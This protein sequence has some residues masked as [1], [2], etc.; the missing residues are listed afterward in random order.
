MNGP[1]LLPSGRRFGPY[2]ERR[3]ET[4]LVSKPFLG[5]VFSRRRISLLVTVCQAGTSLIG[6]AIVAA[7]ICSVPFRYMPHLIQAFDLG[8]NK[9]SAF[10]TLHHAEAQPQVYSDVSPV[11]PVQKLSCEG[12]FSWLAKNYEKNATVQHACLVFLLGDNRL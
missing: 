1:R 10:P 11:A 3:C 6:L 5:L 8:C 4:S 9:T 7:S 2:F 12:H